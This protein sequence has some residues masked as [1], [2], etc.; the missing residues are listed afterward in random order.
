MRNGF[1]R[2]ILLLAAIFGPVTMGNLVSAQNNAPV[3]RIV[4]TNPM[5]RIFWSNNGYYHMLQTATTLT[6]TN[7]WHSFASGFPLMYAFSYFTG[8]FYQ[9]PTATATNNEFYFDQPKYPFNTFFRLKEPDFLPL[10]SF[11]IFYDGLLE[12]SQTAT[13]TVTGPV[14]ANGSIYVG[15][16]QSITFNNPVVCTGSISAPLVDGLTLGWTPSNSAAWNTYFYGTPTNITNIAPLV[17][18]KA[19]NNYHTLIDVPPAGEDPAGFPGYARLFNQA[20]LVLLV[21]NAVAGGYPAVKLVLQTSVNGNLPG[22]DSAPVFILTNY[23]SPLWLANL[24]F[25]SLTNQF[26]DQREYKTNLVTQIDIGVLANWL[27]TNSTVQSKMPMAYGVYPTIL[28]VADQR[29][30][31]PL[32]MT[33]V[34]LVNGITL[35]DS[36]GQGFTVATPNPLYLIGHYNIRP[37]TVSAAL[38]CDAITVL[39]SHWSD[40]ASFTSPYSTGNANYAATDTNTVNGVIVT[41][42]MPSTGVSSTNFSGGVH[43]LV[44]FLEDWSG[45]NLYLNGCRARLWTSQTATNQ[46]RNPYGFSPPPSNGYY[47]PPTRHFSYDVRLST[48]STIPPG[49]PFLNF[50]GTGP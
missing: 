23:A 45:K 47:N 27:Q 30:H 24:P 34:R 18:W 6:T 25:L 29:N 5:T 38:F 41:G 43:N 19:T 4:N 12:F 37:Y 1:Y 44:R 39:S 35:P 21:T 40:S 16:T 14:H 11:S 13:L 8:T 50:S 42:N 3:L 36:A 46:F 33:A 20:Q 28:F 32:Q 48:P 15:T 17:L 9:L 49:V 22:A 7:P 10:S 31:L 2:A 26:Y